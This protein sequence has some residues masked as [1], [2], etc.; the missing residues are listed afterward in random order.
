MLM[1]PIASA[2]CG[3]FG[4][5]SARGPIGLL[6]S[7]ADPP[8]GAGRAEEPIRVTAFFELIDTGLEGVMGRLG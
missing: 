8:G 5:H 2:S 4:P 1:R 3:R 7:T 6:V